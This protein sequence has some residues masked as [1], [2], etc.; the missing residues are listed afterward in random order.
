MTIPGDK[1]IIAFVQDSWRPTCERAEREGDIMVRLV[2]N[3]VPSVSDIF[4][5]GDVIDCDAW[6]DEKGCGDASRFGCKS[7]IKI[8][9]PVI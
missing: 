3:G 4:C 5:Q 9:I 6:L 2:E 7:S 8:I 1:N